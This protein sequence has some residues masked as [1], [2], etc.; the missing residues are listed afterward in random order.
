MQRA[1]ELQSISVFPKHTSNEFLGV[2]PYMCSH[3]EK[4]VFER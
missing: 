2:F 1:L 4:R 3:L